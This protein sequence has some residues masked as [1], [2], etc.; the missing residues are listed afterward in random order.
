M[1]SRSF[2][3][4]DKEMP[5]PPENYGG[6]ALGEEETAPSLKDSSAED[7]KGA[8]ECLKD[9]DNEAKKCGISSHGCGDGLFG[10]LFSGGGFSSLF[11]GGGIKS[12][13][14]KIGTEEILIIATALFLLLSKEGDK[15]CAVM[16]LF[17][18]I[19]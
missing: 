16:L 12:L 13:I 11:G 5:T 8:E 6:T 9:C 1:Y 4:D 2:F 19:I 17:L 14:S 10:G 15:E 18:L 7:A 3:N